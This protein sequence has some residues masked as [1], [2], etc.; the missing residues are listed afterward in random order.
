MIKRNKIAVLLITAILI[1]TFIPLCTAG[2]DDLKDLIDYSDGSTTY[3]EL[4]ASDLL[5][6]AAKVTVLPVEEEYLSSSD[7]TLRY[8]DV[9]P[10]GSVLYEA[11][12]NGLRVTAT[13]YSYVAVNGETVSWIPVA[14]TVNGVKKTFS[15]GV[16][17][18]E[19]EGI[20]DEKACE[21]LTEYKTEIAV[22]PSVLNAL[23]NAGYNEGIRV[24]EKLVDIDA[25][26]SE[27]NRELEIYE[28]DREARDACKNSIK[29]L[30]SVFVADSVG[31]VMYETL[32]GGTV[33]SVIANKDQLVDYGV[34]EEVID[35]AGES[36]ERLIAVLT[37]YNSLTTEKERFEYY[38][39]NYDEI[40]SQFTR[41]CDSLY[42]LA[43]NG[44]IRKEL[45]KREKLERYYQFVAQLYVISAGLDD[46]VTYSEEWNVRG[47]AVTD[48]LE[49]VQIVTDL[50]ASD[51]EDLTYPDSI[52]P[53]EPEIPEITELELAIFEGFSD[54]TLDQRVINVSEALTF[55]A[56]VLRPAEE[57]EFIRGDVNN[58]GAVNNKDVVALFKAVSSG[59]YG[60]N[61]VADFNEDGA[62]N[63]KDVVAL[64]K[65]V[66]S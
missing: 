16:Y 25:A 46:E 42:L 23:A 32:I 22:P 65:H 56:S 39:E 34:N 44:L 64:F 13:P 50:D 43:N 59:E 47:K 5:R 10:D 40:K 62:V 11:T 15:D 36:T 45:T 14:V 17:E 66:S 33:A 60:Y 57:P 52:K 6:E 41:L 29:V 48:V 30:E 3:N 51:P 58:D 27:Y 61:K 26:I 7:I 28:N 54:G 1:F 63:N 37:P 9:I 21:I 35:N 31:H 49:D 8:S 24:F 20:T 38:K 2:A 18:A 12:G 4:P 53:V 55:T 19:F